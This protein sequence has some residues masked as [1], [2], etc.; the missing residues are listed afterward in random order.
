M[1]N[2]VV[3]LQRRVE[4]GRSE[5]QRRWLRGVGNRVRLRML[6]GMTVRDGSNEESGSSF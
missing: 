1:A 4:A 3:M 2:E 5:K 6:R